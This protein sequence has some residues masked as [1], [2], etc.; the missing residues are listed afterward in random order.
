MKKPSYPTFHLPQ[1]PLGQ[2]S[3]S[4]F[5]L[6]LSLQLL[7]LH[8]ETD[9]VGSD[10]WTRD[11]LLVKLDVVSLQHGN[12]SDQHLRGRWWGW[13]AHWHTTDAHLVAVE[14]GVAGLLGQPILL[15]LWITAELRNIWTDLYHLHGQLCR[16]RPRASLGWHEEGKLYKK[17]KEKWKR[18]WGE[19]MCGQL[20]PQT[21]FFSAQVEIK[22][23]GSTFFH[24][25]LLL[26]IYLKLIRE[27]QG[28]KV[29]SYCIQTPK[30]PGSRASSCGHWGTQPVLQHITDTLSMRVIARRLTWQ[31]GSTSG[32]NCDDT[33]WGQSQ[34]S[35]RKNTA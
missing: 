14:G 3:T 15:H 9:G 6:E 32:R 30:P 34:R 23:L 27:R 1:L 35:K 33:H 31:L 10:P 21:S 22:L 17:K 28:W 25:S 29:S 4:A 20:T 7:D 24:F 8:E 26:T 13:C 2:D 5:I 11:V 16:A 12:S 19:E 18:M